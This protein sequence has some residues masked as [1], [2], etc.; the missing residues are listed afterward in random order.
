MTRRDELGR[1]W[2]VTWARI[3]GRSHPGYDV[4]DAVGT[5]MSSLMAFSCGTSSRKPE[6]GLGVVVR[7]RRRPIALVSGLPDFVHS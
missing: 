3:P 2:L 7:T 6:V 4:F 5:D 1:R